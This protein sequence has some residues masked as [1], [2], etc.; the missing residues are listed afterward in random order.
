MDSMLECW[1]VVRGESVVR[2]HMLNQLF[3][4]GYTAA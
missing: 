2:N 1:E 4:D 3:L